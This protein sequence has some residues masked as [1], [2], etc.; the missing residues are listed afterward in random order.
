MA[1][2]PSLVVEFAFLAERA[3]LRDVQ[4]ARVYVGNGAE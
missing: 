1:G 3:Q 2:W 4:V